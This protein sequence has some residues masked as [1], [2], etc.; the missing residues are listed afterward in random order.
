MY[1]LIH[2]NNALQ[3]ENNML[4]KKLFPSAKGN[5]A[6]IPFTEIILK[7]ESSIIFLNESKVNNRVCVLSKI[8]L[9]P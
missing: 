1:Q 7:F 8:P 2:E 5:G 6:G 3:K 4:L 9:F